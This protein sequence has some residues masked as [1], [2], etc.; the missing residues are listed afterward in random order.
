M[1]FVVAIVIESGNQDVVDNPQES[2]LA[3]VNRV[4]EETERMN[5][6]T[7]NAVH[8]IIHD[9]NGN[10]IGHAHIDHEVTEQEA[11]E[12]PACSE[13]SLINTSGKEYECSEC[14]H[15][16]TRGIA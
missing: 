16:E 4:M 1:K 14:K 13:I 11:M 15:Y 3:V 8:A 9:A 10:K 2:A 6:E 12:C 7:N 5:F